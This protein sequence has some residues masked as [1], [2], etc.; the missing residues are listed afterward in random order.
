MQLLHAL[1]LF[2]L[3][4]SAMATPVPGKIIKPPPPYTNAGFYR[5]YQSASEKLT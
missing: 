5:D 4:I 2:L 3:S 1:A